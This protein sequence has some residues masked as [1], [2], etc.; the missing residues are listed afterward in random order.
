MRFSLPS[1]LWLL[2]I[3]V[4]SPIGNFPLN[5]DWAYAHSVFQLVEHGRFVLDDWPAMTLLT[6]ILWGSL[7]CTIFGFSFTVLR[8]AVLFQAWLGAYIFYRIL[9][10]QLQWSRSSASLGAAVLLFH[11]MYYLLSFSFMTDVPFLLYLLAAT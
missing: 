1:L 10:D 6:H 11:P 9:L 7:W 2:S 4:I 5:D 3:F 8:I